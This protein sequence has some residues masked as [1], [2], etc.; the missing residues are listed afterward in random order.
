MKKILI[1]IAAL[2]AANGAYAAAPGAASQEPS[3]NFSELS[4]CGASD[5]GHAFQKPDSQAFP[6]SNPPA[7]ACFKPPVR[8]DAYGDIY[9]GKTLLG[10]GATAFKTGCTNDV[11]WTDRTG[12]LHRNEDIIGRDASEY[13]LAAFTG[14]VIWT[15]HYSYLFRNGFRIGTDAAKHEI[16]AFS[17]Q[18]IWSDRYGYLYRNDGQKTD[19]IGADVK[20]YKVS[21]F[22]PAVVWLDVFRSIYLNDRGATSRIGTDVKKYSVSARTGMAAWL[23]SRGT[24]FNHGLPLARDVRDY[25]QDALGNITWTDMAGVQHGN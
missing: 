4:R 19:R 7:S 15:D 21:A 5:I 25:S 3:V 22:T 20:E 14:D 12:Y 2:A 13:E 23:D 17:G 6:Q 18:V 1:M 10:R 11:A 9:N 8:I 16:N 24:L